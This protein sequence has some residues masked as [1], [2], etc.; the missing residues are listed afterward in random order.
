MILTHLNTTLLALKPASL[1]PLFPS[2]LNDTIY[3]LDSEAMQL[4]I[5]FSFFSSSISILDQ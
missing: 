1:F 4:F 5:F 2:S 3:L